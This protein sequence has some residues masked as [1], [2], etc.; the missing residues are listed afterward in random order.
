MSS[1]LT[2]VLEAFCELLPYHPS[3]FRPFV[4]QLRELLR[5]L[6][7]PTPSNINSEGNTEVDEKTIS[8]ATASSARRLLVVLCSC[9]PKN[10]SSQEWVQSLQKVGDQ[11]HRT[12][13]LVFRAMIEDLAPSRAIQAE[14][15]QR[16]SFDAMLNEP[17]EDLLDLPSWTGIHGG[18]ER[19]HGQIKTLQAFLT[20]TTP[21][22]VAFPL[23][24]V[25][26]VAKR[27]L[28]ILPPGDV[29]DQMNSSNR[30][31]PEV[32]REEREA[33]LVALPRL[34]VSAINLIMSL[35][36]RFER[37]LAA[38][39]NEILGRILRT[40][41]AQ[42]DHDNVRR[43]TYDVLSLYLSSFG[44]TTPR[45]LASMISNCVESACEDLLP[46]NAVNQEIAQN[47]S[48]AARQPGENG[49][50]SKSG[51]S[52]IRSTG[53]ITT[54]PVTFTQT[55]AAART[56][57]C[58]ALRDLPNDFLLP[59]ARNQVDVASIL[60]DDNEELMEASIMNPTSQTQDEEQRTI[61]PFLARKFARCER[62]EAL[63]R[64]RMPSLQLR[65][66][67][68]IIPIHSQYVLEKNVSS[69]GVPV[70]V[71][72]AIYSKETVPPRSS[73]KPQLS[74]PLLEPNTRNQVYEKRAESTSPP[75]VPSK[76]SHEPVTSPVD[77]PPAPGDAPSSTEEHRSKRLHLARDGV[78]DPPLGAQSLTT[79]L[80]EPH[81]PSQLKKLSPPEETLPDLKAMDEIRS[82]DDSDDSAIPPID[83]EMPSDE[84]SE[85]I[86]GDEEDEKSQFGS[87][88]LT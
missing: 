35:L 48:E 79:K 3:I 61:L 40:F 22:S 78:Y 42:R 31:N 1:I 21:S 14:N 54:F 26:D 27:V 20:T 23:E 73:E 76:R 41:C 75:T 29:Q 83:L 63:T 39:I 47:G 57:I 65:P 30:I 51:N 33:L 67:D 9:A 5:Y 25:A 24:K 12:A 11:C 66:L 46:S 49:G 44:P 43:A 16:K 58:S 18:I 38:S 36:M 69:T 13:D 52:Y 17:R 4:G 80:V 50:P 55:K 32:D 60:V 59:N 7:A 64:P 37:G 34:H 28:S 77:K 15:A 70:V 62:V 68:N 74:D 8:E 56:L 45:A 81:E 71:D 84:D 86:D 88:E 53:Q 2:T 10:T 87:K 85:G 6:L 72:A 82:D 19:L